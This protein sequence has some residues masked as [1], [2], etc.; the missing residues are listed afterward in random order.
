MM[1][2]T[3][4][5]VACGGNADCPDGYAKTNDDLCV[6]LDDPTDIIDINVNNGDDDDDDDDDDNQD[7]QDNGKPVGDWC[8]D[9]PDCK[10][11]LLCVFQ[12][13]DD[14]T[15]VCTETCNSWADC[16]ESFWECC[17]MSNGGFVCTPDSWVDELGLQCQ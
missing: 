17:D 3:L 16:S 11:D 2:T 13:G 15:G 6:S 9:T 5:L 7:N 1:F 4:L 14:N 10:N 12:Y 8:Y